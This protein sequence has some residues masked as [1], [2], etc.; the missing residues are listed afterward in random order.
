[1]NRRTVKALHGI[2]SLRNP[3]AE[4]AV[5]PQQ[6]GVKVVISGSGLGCGV[7]GPHNGTDVRISMSDNG[8]LMR[9]LLNGHL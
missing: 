5:V 3:N 6:D 1:M 7:S 8:P 4:I 9:F 2:L